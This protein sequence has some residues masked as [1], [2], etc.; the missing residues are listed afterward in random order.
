MRFAQAASE[1]AQRR[2]Y[3]E[4]EIFFHPSVWAKV[5]DEDGNEL[6]GPTMQDGPR[7]CVLALVGPGSP[8][9]V[10]LTQASDVT[11]LKPPKR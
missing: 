6:M 8:R 4:R 5:R 1:D 7:L 2:R 9:V 11:L 10:R 3:G